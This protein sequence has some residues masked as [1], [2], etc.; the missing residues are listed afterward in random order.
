M[1]ASVEGYL[2]GDKVKQAL[3]NVTFLNWHPG[4]QDRGRGLGFGSA[5]M[6]VRE[7]LYRQ[8]LALGPTA[9]K[10]KDLL[11]HFPW[12]LHLTDPV[13]IDSQESL[14]Y[15]AQKEKLIRV[16]LTQHPGLDL[17]ALKKQADRAILSWIHY[18]RK[19]HPNT[20]YPLWDLAETVPQAQNSGPKKRKAERIATKDGDGKE[21]S[22]VP[23]HPA[24]RQRTEQWVNEV[25]ESSRTV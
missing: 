4:E 7:W 15:C 3:A 6:H 5:K 21:S 25:G 18:L 1:L 9:P 23:Q 24:K 2:T 8:K 10:R 20:V 16:A 13:S 14:S 11:K 19:T 22:A 12:S 17:V